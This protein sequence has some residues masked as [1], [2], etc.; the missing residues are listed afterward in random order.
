[1]LDTKRRKNVSVWK[2]DYTE[3]RFIENSNKLIITDTLYINVIFVACWQQCTPQIQTNVWRKIN[4]YILYI[5]L[6]TDLHH[7]F[8][9]HKKNLFHH[10]FLKIKKNKWHRLTMLSNNYIVFH[11]EIKRVSSEQFQ[12]S[13]STNKLLQFF[14]MWT[15]C[16]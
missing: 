15:K 13:F 10:F 5:Y 4:S 8:P 6:D 2:W 3:Y 12:D 9:F 1:M 16:Y 14:C 11:A 7:N